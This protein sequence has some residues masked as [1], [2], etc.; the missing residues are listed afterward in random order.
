MSRNSSCLKIPKKDGEKTLS[1]TNKIELTDK[2]LCFQRTEDALWIPLNRQPKEEE[3]AQLRL[4]VPNFELTAQEFSEKAQREVTLAEVLAGELPPNLLARLPRALDVVGDI[5]ILEVPAELEPHKKALGE[6]IL[7]THRNVHTVLAKAGAISGTYRV[8]DLEFLAGENKTQ[9]L[10][11]EYGCTYYVDVAKA[12]FSPRLSTEHMRV[13]SL[14][15][16]SEVVVDLF[17]GVGPFVVPIAK[18]HVDVKVYAV[19]INPDAVELLKRNIRLNRVDDRV[20]PVLGDARNIVKEKLS[21]AADR[22]IMNLPETANE[23]IDVACKALKPAGGVVH[24]Y[25]F[26]CHP[27]TVQDLAKEF[28]VAVEKEGWKVVATQYAKTVR[29]TAPY[30]WQ[31]V[32]D[33]EVK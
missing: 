31:A 29:E 6:A 30:E 8:R 16:P 25:G 32:L 1:F 9:T 3:L 13:A 24:F 5:A 33:A 7:K 4:Q 21:G 19:D 26:M 22:V 27:Q 28:R 11:K 12:Y 2:T 20:V 17:A 10:H 15:Q 14:V 23:F 18:R